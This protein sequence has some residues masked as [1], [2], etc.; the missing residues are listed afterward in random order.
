MKEWVVHTIKSAKL[1]SLSSSS[2]WTAVPIKNPSCLKTLPLLTPE[3][4]VWPSTLTS[5]ELNNFPRRLCVLSSSSHPSNS[6]LRTCMVT[7]MVL[8]FMVKLR[9]LFH[10]PN[11]PSLPTRICPLMLISLLKASKTHL[12]L[13][14]SN[15]SLLLAPLLMKPSC[16][17][18]SL[19]STR[20]LD[21]TL[22][23]MSPL[24]WSSIIS[25]IMLP[26]L[27]ITLGLDS[28]LT[29]LLRMVPMSPATSRLPSWREL[30]NLWLFLTLLNIMKSITKVVLLPLKLLSKLMYE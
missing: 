6:S 22:L 18:S 29:S 2:I 26:L 20:E 7:G 13:T 24:V 27:L 3:L 21:L 15:C 25:R 5:P 14:L 4:V 28:R 17:L 30:L 19:H 1:T 11:G 10:A 16:F 8:L 9:M 23:T 12:R